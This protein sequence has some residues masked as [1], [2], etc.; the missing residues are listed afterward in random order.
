MAAVMRAGGGLVDSAWKVK[1]AVERSAPDLRPLKPHVIKRIMKTFLGAKWQKVDTR[2]AKI[3]QP[4]EQRSRIE[5]AKVFIALHECGFDF[6]YQD[7]YSCQH[8][9]NKTY[10]WRL[11]NQQTFLIKSPS[12]KPVYLSLIHI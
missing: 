5:F 12:K 7:E 8:L 4:A 10:A 11:P 2:A 9:P 6:I 1:L 3:S